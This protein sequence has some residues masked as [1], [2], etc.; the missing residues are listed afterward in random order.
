MVSKWDNNETLDTNLDPSGGEPYKRQ[1]CSQDQYRRRR[2]WFV[3]FID[4][5]THLSWVYLITNKFEVK[6]VFLIFYGR[7]ET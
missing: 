5:H 3:T 4:D 6:D 2:Q 7:I 1:D